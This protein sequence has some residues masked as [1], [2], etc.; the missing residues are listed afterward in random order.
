MDAFEPVTVSAGT[1]VIEQ[2]QGGDVFYV[3]EDGSLEIY[4]KNL[5]GVR[6]PVGSPLGTG[7]HFGELALMYNTPRAASIK[8][9][10]DCKLWQIDRLTYRGIILQA[11][12][13][14]N[15][16]YIELLENVT[17][18]SKRLGDLLSNSKFFSYLVACFMLVYFL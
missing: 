6:V 9:T 2:G 13:A 17:I 3:V 5:E 14:Q 16:K 18:N 1:F 8:A 4:V 10:T 15:K 11:K 12:Y 7:S